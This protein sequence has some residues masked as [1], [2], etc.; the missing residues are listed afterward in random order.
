MHVF[1]YVRRQEDLIS[2]EYLLS[3]SNQLVW[4]VPSIII[5]T[6]W[7]LL[8]VPAARWQVPR[9]LT[10]HYCSNRLLDWTQDRKDVWVIG[11]WPFLYP[12]PPP[13]PAPS[14]THPPGMCVQYLMHWEI[15]HKEDNLGTNP[16]KVIIWTNDSKFF[17]LNK[18]YIL[19][20]YNK[21]ISGRKFII[22]LLLWYPKFMYQPHTILFIKCL[23]V[24]GWYTLVT[25]YWSN[26]RSFMV[27]TTAL[28]RTGRR[29]CWE[30]N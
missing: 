3:W 7:R 25:K 23:S 28:G 18:C 24:S 6:T 11:L 10:A 26:Y 21:K 14:P 8:P 16:K 22:F 15:T 1:I 9:F 4:H 29:I 17:F 13:Y 19:S 30:T 20:F 5:I 12:L 27:W 2:P